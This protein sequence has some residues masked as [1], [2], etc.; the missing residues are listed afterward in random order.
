FRRPLGWLVANRPSLDHL[1]D[2]R[3]CRRAA[4]NF[5]WI[6]DVVQAFEGLWSEALKLSRSAS[7]SS[8]TTTYCSTKTGMSSGFLP[9]ARAPSCHSALCLTQKPALQLEAV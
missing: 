1:L 8:P 7:P 5:R 2:W 6:A 9:A 3:L 4:L